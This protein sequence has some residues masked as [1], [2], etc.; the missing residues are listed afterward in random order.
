MCSVLA[1]VVS[2]GIKQR[3]ADVSV[4]DSARDLGQSYILGG[5]SPV[6]LTI[7]A[8]VSCYRMLDAIPGIARG[9]PSAMV[10]KIATLAVHLIT[11]I[12]RRNKATENR[13]GRLIRHSV[14]S[15]L[16]N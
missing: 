10:P 12:I 2:V 13:C 7:A 11:Q 14:C 4:R 16:S 5:W 8:A 1:I 9:C 6:K 15:G 3:K